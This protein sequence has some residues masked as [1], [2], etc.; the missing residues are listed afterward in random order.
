MWEAA[1][2]TSHIGKLLL[3]TPLAPPAQLTRLPVHA[4]I[5]PLSFSFFCLHCFHNVC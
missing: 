1:R 3:P 2:A 4:R 5:L